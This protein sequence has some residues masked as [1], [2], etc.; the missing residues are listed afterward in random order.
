MGRWLIS[1]SGALSAGATVVVVIVTIG[2]VNITSEMSRRQGTQTDEMI[3]SRL[4]AKMPVVATSVETF[5]QP[6]SSLVTVQCEI[7][8]IGKFPAK[9]LGPLRRGASSLSTIRHGLKR[10]T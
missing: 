6:R 8:N 2:Y 9:S 3:K 4:D 5:H 1:Y 7:E 10:E